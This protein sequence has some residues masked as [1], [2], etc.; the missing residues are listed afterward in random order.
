MKKLLL[1]ILVGI[2]CYAIDSGTYICA[3]HIENKVIEN[4]MIFKLYDN[5]K[6]KVEV[7]EKPWLTKYGYWQDYGDEALIIDK[8][9]VLVE[10]DDDNYNLANTNNMFRCKRQ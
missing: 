7:K 10:I 6:A 1:G 8:K 9:T 5:G 4:A 2:N 3:I